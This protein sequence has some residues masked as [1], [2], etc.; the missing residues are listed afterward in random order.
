LAATNDNELARKLKVFQENL[1]EPSCFWVFQQLLH[2]ILTR[3]FVMPLYNFGEIGK[4][5]LISLQKI[6]LLSKAVSKKEKQGELPTKSARKMPEALAIITLSQFE[7][8]EKFISHQRQIAGLY[9]KNLAGL[10]L[11]LPPSAEGRIYLRYP[12]LLKNDNADMI[13]DK[14][15]K[16][17]IFLDDGWRKTVVVPPDTNQDK[18]GYRAG[19]CPIAEKVS[20]KIFN[21]PTHINISEQ[22]AQ[23]IINLLKNKLTET[24]S[25]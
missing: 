12:V 3:F 6:G 13:L 14:A 2:P 23:R 24:R 19:D 1:P 22:K 18:M 17:K 20:Q 11:T 7:K 21:L 25:L 15:R 10:R 16:E 4:W 9:D 5:K 8:L